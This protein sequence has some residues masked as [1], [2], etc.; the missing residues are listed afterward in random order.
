M[1]GELIW[2]STADRVRLHG[3]LIDPLPAR[4]AGPIDGAVILHGLGGNFYSSGLLSFLGRQFSTLEI[5]VIMGNTRGHDFLNMTTR[6]GRSQINGSAMEDVAECRFDIP[7]WAEYLRLNRGCQRVAIVGHSLGAIK[8]IYSEAYE[9][10]STVAAIAS[11]SATRLNHEQ[12]VNCSA[13]QAFLNSYQHAVRLVAE[14]QTKE[15]VYFDFP[16]PTWMQPQSYLDKYGPENHFDWVKIIEMIQKP[17]LMTFGQMELDEHPA[18]EGV[19]EVTNTVASRM[20]NLTSV[21][22]KRADHFYVAAFDGLWQAIDSWLE[23]LA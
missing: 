4:N 20:R 15:L 14:G 1:K 16:F 22:I 17:M 13:R 8:A 12:F 9:P 10:N 2:T 5:P 3:F 21:K 19:E 7:A 23:S 11:L 18:F 6:A